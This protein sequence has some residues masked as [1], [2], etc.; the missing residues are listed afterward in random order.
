VS[1]S[2]VSDEGEGSDELANVDEREEVVPKRRAKKFKPDAAAVEVLTRYL[3]HT[4]I[5]ATTVAVI[6]ANEVSP[7][8]AFSGKQL[9]AWLKRK[10]TQQRAPSAS[11][12]TAGVASSSRQRNPIRRVTHSSSSTSTTSTSASTVSTLALSTVH[13]PCLH[14]L[15][16]PTV[17]SSSQTAMPLHVIP[18]SLANEVV[19]VAQRRATVMPPVSVDIGPITAPGVGMSR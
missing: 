6:N 10:R 7:D 15:S 9:S 19:S 3:E 2:D 5:D 16:P 14:Q 17:G 13:A 12:H 8:F 18:S 11:A 1:V 4:R